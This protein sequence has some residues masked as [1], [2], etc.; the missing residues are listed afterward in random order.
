MLEM[1]SFSNNI[2]ISP[3]NPIQISNPNPILEENVEEKEMETKTKIYIAIFLILPSLIYFL[4]TLNSQPIFLAKNTE[5]RR[6]NLTIFHDH[7]ET[8]NSFKLA[9][10]NRQAI[11]P[12]GI[13]SLN[14]E[15][16]QIIGFFDE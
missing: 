14:Y 16:D 13:S 11:L 3:R 9:L 2:S 15:N 7:P 1:T 8:Q 12:L 6:M 10:E 4:V 5:I